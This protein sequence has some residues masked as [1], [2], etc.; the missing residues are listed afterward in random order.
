MG[1]T[2]EDMVKKSM[3]QYWLKTN[4]YD[5]MPSQKNMKYNKKYFDNLEKET[6]PADTKLSKPNV[7]KL[8]INSL[9]GLTPSGPIPGENYT[10][11]TKNYPWHRPPEVTSL[12]QGIELAGKQLMSEEAGQGLIT[13]LSV[14]LD[15]ATLTDLFV[16]SGIGAGKWT[17]DFAIL[18]AGPVS[19][20][21]QLLAKA[22]GIDADLGIDLP[23]QTKTKSYLHTAIMDQV[24]FQN[25]MKALD[26][27]VTIQAAEEAVK[28]QAGGFMG[29]GQELSKASEAPQAKIEGEQ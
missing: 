14:G 11:D 16:T 4:E 26:D 15:I 23:R 22:N 24:N 19:H 25:V 5:Q 13:M 29:Y 20:I 17:P 12:D 28:Q 3:R 27:P 18:L 9:K 21:I 7:P 10:S 2:F 8:D 6:L 1:V